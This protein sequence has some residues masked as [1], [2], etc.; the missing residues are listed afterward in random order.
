M[1]KESLSNGL[2]GPLAYIAGSII[3]WVAIEAVIATT[4]LLLNNDPGL[5]LKM[6]SPGATLGTCV[7]A[8]LYRRCYP[9]HMR[10]GIALMLACALVGGIVG[11]FFD[12]LF[13]H[14]PVLSTWQRIVIL[15]VPI[16]ALFG[17]SV[18]ALSRLVPRQ[19]TS[20]QSLRRS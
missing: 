2:P 7:G 3:S 17:C 16:G 6:L 13:Q 10:R 1:P 20:E 11:W 5:T 14:C 9:N 4:L 12:I 8:D 18:F 15:G 19:P